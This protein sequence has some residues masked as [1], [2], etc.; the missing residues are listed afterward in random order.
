LLM[1]AYYPSTATIEVE[2][3]RSN[4]MDSGLGQLAG[5][6]GS[7]P[8]LE[9]ETE[10]S[11]LQSDDLALETMEKTHY[12]E[13]EAQYSLH[14][15]GHKGRPV[16][17][18]GLPLAQAPLTRK[19]LLTRFSKNLKVKMTE[20]TRLILVTIEDPDPKFAAELCSTLIDSYIKDRLSRRNSST[21]EA[22]EWMDGEIDGMKKQVDTTQ[23]ALID[24]EQK[25]GLLVLPAPS[26]GASAGAA[27]PTP[28][29]PTVQSPELDRFVELNH[30]LVGAETDRISK[31][32]IYRVAQTGDPNAL[33]QMGESLSAAPGGLTASQADL[34][35][36]LL[37][38]R[39]QE[40]AL[41]L[42]LASLERTY[43]PNNPHIE[44]LNRQLSE[45]SDQMRAEAK[46]VVNR[47]SLDFEF[48][49][50]NE[51]ALRVRY[52]TELKSAYDINN[53]QIHLAI[54]QEEADSMR[55]LYE[56]SRT[57]LL[58]AK[59]QIGMQAANIGLISRPLPQP[60]PARP[61][62]VLYTIIAIP[63][64]LV[65]AGIAVFVV[66]SLDD[67]FSTTQKI[68]ET[69][70]LPVV[71]MIPKF[72]SSANSGEGGAGKPAETSS[73]Q[74]RQAS[75]LVRAPRSPISEA[76][77][78]LRTSILLSKPG[79]APK[80]LLVTSSV[81]EEGKSATVYNMAVCFAQMG[82]KVLVIE[83]DLRKPSLRR[84]TG[85]ESSGGLSNLLTGSMDRHQFLLQD[86]DL[87]NLYLLLAGPIPPNSSELLISSTFDDLLEE[88][89]NEFDLVLLD[90]PPTVL[91]TDAA[92][93]SG[94]KVNG[95]L[96]VVRADSTTRSALMRTVETLRRSKAHILGV[97]LNLIDTSSSEYYYEQGYYYRGGEAYYGENAK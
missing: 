39:Q 21:L 14:L 81:P 32:A 12:E 88:Y 67:T 91:L 4:P 95:V 11:V 8:A 19:K 45:I 44:D 54:L 76:F 10:V 52:D 48:S 50:K 41:K 35:G 61:Q 58:E 89:S 9:L 92:I 97:V 49:K 82:K 74:R 77:R 57:K 34:F 6:M 55:M 33:A 25:S 65:L 78:A 56:A 53:A 64:G 3:D 87:E 66:D 62:P 26:S 51:D 69:L 75:W 59:M 2:P 28:S 63:L 68:E 70:G 90:S 83:C 80:V 40:V 79:S 17:E 47:A 37:S 36:G 43:G 84:Y 73:A 93:I 15:F 30:S 18:V 72:A 85:Q 94:K 86:P 22:T 20:G 23:N 7:D 71:G 29:V 42:Q 24:F 31:E 27:T 13:K 96:V 60:D 16:G 46:R 5:A 38:L 1:R